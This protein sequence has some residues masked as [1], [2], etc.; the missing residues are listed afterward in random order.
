MVDLLLYSTLACADADAI[1]L[2]MK[3]NEDL[4]Q[5]VRIELIET[6]KEST[7]HCYWDAND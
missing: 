6:V 5:V 1:M 3:A 7:P 2:R 4:P